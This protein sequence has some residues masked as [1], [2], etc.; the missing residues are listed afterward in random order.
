ML[1]YVMNFL[2]VPYCRLCTIVDA[3][4][5]SCRTFLAITICANPDV[6]QRKNSLFLH[7][8]SV[9]IDPALATAFAICASLELEVLPLN[10]LPYDVFV[11]VNVDDDRG[12]RRLTSGSSK[13]FSALNFT[14][15]ILELGCDDGG[16][17]S[18]DLRL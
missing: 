17:D 7:T 8:P 9:A 18:R 2:H 12:P 15:G 3:V 6:G 14:I 13:I 11:I 16:N 10:A 4:S 5:I 1:S